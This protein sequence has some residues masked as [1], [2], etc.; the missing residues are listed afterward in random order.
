MIVEFDAEPCLQ[1]EAAI[2]VAEVGPPAADQ[3]LDIGFDQ[4]RSSVLLAVGE[5][6]CLRDKRRLWSEEFGSELF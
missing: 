2:T 3:P 1:A 6:A 5:V 4:D